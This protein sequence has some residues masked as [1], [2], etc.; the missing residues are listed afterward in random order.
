MRRVGMVE[1]AVLLHLDPLTVVVLV[2]LGDV[3]PTLAVF[4]GEGHLDPLV[5][6]HVRIFFPRRPGREGASRT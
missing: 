5:G 3:V 1:G 2:L 6:R 4:A